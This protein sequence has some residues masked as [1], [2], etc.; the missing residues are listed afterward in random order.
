MP[1]S[2][3]DK[4]FD[5]T[6]AAFAAAVVWTLMVLTTGSAHAFDP[7]KT[8]K[9]N[10]EPRTILRFG[11]QALKEGNFADALG[12]FRFGAQKNDLASQWKLAR[13]LQSGAGLPKDDLG[14]YK[15]YAEITARYRDKLP[16]RSNFPYVSNA[17]VALGRY[18]LSGIK[19][20]SVGRSPRR[21]E[22]HFYRAAALY[23][24][25]EAQYELGLM[26]RKGLLGTKQPKSAAR[27]FGLSARKGHKQAQAELGE[28][29]FY[30]D[31]VRSNPVRGLVYITR[32]AADSARSGLKSIDDMRKE[33]LKQAS[34]AQRDAAAKIISTLNLD[35]DSFGG[36]GS[37]PGRK[38]KAKT[39]KPTPRSK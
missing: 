21:A 23:K 7:E 29:L 37:K 33:A 39:T 28:M 2:K 24:D 4:R 30:G 8:F 26:Y 27:W 34:A 1:T 9:N 16:R 10:D 32:A 38:S 12:A 15:L 5:L 25:R 14:A 22:R 18:R 31:G 20:S 19:G 17:H 3:S 13:M 36:A 6:L 35:E 11:F